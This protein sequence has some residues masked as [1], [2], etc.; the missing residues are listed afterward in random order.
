MRL[1]GP[2]GATLTASGTIG[3]LAAGDS[4]SAT[5]GDATAVSLGAVGSTACVEVGT[6]AWTLG[7]AAGGALALSAEPPGL[8]SRA[9]LTAV[10][11]GAPAA[12]GFTITGPE[13]GRDAIAG[14][15]GAV[16]TICGACLGSGTTLRGAGAGCGADAPA[17]EVGA[18]AMLPV[19][20]TGGTVPAGIA[21]GVAAEAETVGATEDCRTEGD[22]FAATL[23]ASRCSFCC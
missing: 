12:A 10:A 15:A 9:F 13:G 20:A 2:V 23:P 14:V 21:L 5:A 17:V 3:E 8:V 1:T 16:T 18:A 4:A 7:F 22:G 11:A 19:F 6:A